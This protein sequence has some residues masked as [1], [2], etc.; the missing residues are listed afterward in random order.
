MEAILLCNEH[1]DAINGFY[2]SVMNRQPIVREQ[3]IDSFSRRRVVAMV[4]STSCT[5]MPE[6]G[7]AG[8]VNVG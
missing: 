6:G 2:S 8:D 7:S 1:W 3:I 4:P 5:V